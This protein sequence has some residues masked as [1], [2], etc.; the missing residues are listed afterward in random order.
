[1]QY[2]Y[3]IVIFIISADLCKKMYADKKKTLH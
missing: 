3:I 2:L 1:M